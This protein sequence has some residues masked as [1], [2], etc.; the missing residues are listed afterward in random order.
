MKTY[1]LLSIILLFSCYTNP[2]I[3]K[4]LYDNGQIRYLFEKE[5]GKKH[6][7][8]KYWDEKGNIINTVEYFYGQLHGE[9][10]RYYS[11]GRIKS[12]TIYEFD[13]KNGYEKTFYQNGNIKSQ[14][15]YKDDQ[16]VSDIIRWDKNG[17]LMN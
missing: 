11:N 1:L 5:N 6:G 16:E 13:K 3:E 14:V 10:I 2:N 8:S 9:W 12:I 15:L 4:S 7:L 17:I